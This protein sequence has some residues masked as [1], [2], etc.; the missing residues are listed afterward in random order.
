MTAL[1]W[2]SLWAQQPPPGQG[3]GKEYVLRVNAQDI[4]VI[5]NA[6][7]ERAYKEVAQLLQKL[8]AQI[9]EQDRPQAPGPGPQQ[10]QK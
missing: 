8:Q 5:G 3:P 4:E 7:R 9:I 10:E 1:S 2:T 6:L